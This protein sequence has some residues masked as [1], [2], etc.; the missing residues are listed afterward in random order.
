MR[1]YDLIRKKREGLSLTKAEIDFIVEGFTAGKIPDYQMAALAMAVYFR[2]MDREETLNLT[3]AMAASGEMLDLSGVPG[4]KVDKHSTGGVADTTT[5]VL[6]P[7]VAACGVPVAKLSG[8]GLGYTGG[9]VDKL[10]AIPG[11]RAEISREEFIANLKRYGIAVA[12]QSAEITPADGKLYA[13][14]DVTATVDSIPLIASSVMSKKIAA[15]ADA[16]V[17][18]VKV[19]RGAFMKDLASARELARA[20]VGIGA[21]AGRETVAYITAMDQPLGLAIGNGLEVT[22]AIQVLR[23]GGS[24]DLV[25]LCL[26]LGSVMLIL[27][28]R[29]KDKK[30]ARQKL[31]QALAGGAALEKFRQLIAVQGG[32]GRVVDDPSLLPRARYQE[33]WV[34]EG[35]VYPAALP[36]DRL[37]EIAMKLGA[38][39]EKKEDPIDPAVGIVLGGKVGDLIRKGQPVATV[40]ANDP[41][42]LEEALAEL[43]SCIVLSP[44]PVTPPPLVLEEIRG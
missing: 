15:G 12:A 9:T 10:E 23:G 18:D 35:D 16:I 21:A 36:A 43:K 19:G 7:L 5:L 11:F 4:I 17:L 6:A 31:E 28:G 42:R 14:R 8:R 27:G 22:E 38:G 39:R 33:A 26:E 3:L 40:Y 32:D 1:M 20:M 24:R 44:D 13:L 30:E 25:A 41:E 29:A 37:G 34:A 2:G